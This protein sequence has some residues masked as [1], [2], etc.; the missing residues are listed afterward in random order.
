MLFAVGGRWDKRRKRW[1]DEEPRSALQ[2]KL[3]PGQLEGAEFF[4]EWFEAYQ[5]GESLDPDIYSALFLGGSRAGKTALAKFITVAFMAA[6]PNARVWLVQP[7]K[8][9][10]DD[11]LENEFDEIIP[12]AWAT[13][14]GGKYK[15][16]NGTTATIRSAKYPHALKKGRC[17][18]AFLNEGQNVPE[19]SF[20]MLRM[21]TSDSGGLVIVAANPPN[22][23][24]K[25]EWIGTWAE[26]D[27]RGERPHQ[28]LFP[29]DPRDNPHVRREQLLAIAEETD[30]RTYEI[31]VLGKVLPPSDAVYHAFS[32]IENVDAIP[33]IGNITGAFAKRAGLGEGVRDLIGLDFQRTPHMAAAACRAFDNPDDPRALLY[34][35]KA[36]TVDLGDEYDLSDALYE[37][38]FR[39]ETTALVGDA[40]GE[41]QDADRTKGGRSFDILRE[42]GW[43]RLFVPDRNSRKNPPLGERM[44]NDNRLFMSEAGQRL[45][46]IDP[47]ARE[48]I[49]ACKKWRNT[50]SGV[51][52]RASKYAHICDSMSYLNWRV[53]PRKV[54]RFDVGYKRLKGRKR[55]GQLKGI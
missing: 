10:D 47:E 3:H 44:K 4:A 28:K 11:E 54:W 7:T 25:G 37:A 55:R 38:G 22:S 34:F 15:M 20:S 26:A 41:W 18:F 50:S 52:Y 32:P 48:L 24:N 33:E 23:G 36:I 51:P 2:I 39:P 16:V 46:M 45:V 27:A 12:A 49:E 31:E 13:K 21:R 19:L 14:N 9:I 5:S 43:R 35:W 30:H 40:S 53:Y 17:D 29:F 1:A 42:C 8:T 6:V